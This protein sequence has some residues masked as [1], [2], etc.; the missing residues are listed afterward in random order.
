MV[1]GFCAIFMGDLQS[2]CADRRAGISGVSAPGRDAVPDGKGNGTKD[3]V[4]R[5]SGLKAELDRDL[6]NNNWVEVETRGIAVNP[7]IYNFVDLFSGAGGMSLGFSQAGFRKILSVEI[8]RDASRT[9][10]A[11]FP[12]SSHIERDI[13]EVSAAEV[14]ALVAD[15]PVHVVCGGPP[16]GGFSVAGLRNPD[17][18]RNQLF[19]E[20]LRLVQEINP[21]FVV[22]ENVP[23]ILTLRKGEF[24]REIVRQFARAGYPALSVRILEAA[25]Y[26]TPQLR[27]R[28]IFVANR[29]GVKNPYPAEQ[30]GRANYNSIASSIDDLKTLPPDPS[31]NHEWTK[32]SKRMEARIAGVPPGGS[33]YDNFRDAW[34]RQHKGVPSMAVKENHGGVHIHYELNRVLSARELARLQTF[35]DS[36]IFSGTMKRAYWQIGNAVPCLLAQN[37]ALSLRPSLKELDRRD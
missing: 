21:L 34:K 25:A 37:I 6:F 33:L 12:D 28:A 11:N 35:P 30:L 15:R 20:F 8:D 27:T 5:Y 23:G 3:A 16:C 9:I 17:D 29:V 10:R 7:H 36:F 32:H 1:K 2:S 19:Q 22:M 26:G 24:Y 31:F 13:R 14:A 18:Q 4:S